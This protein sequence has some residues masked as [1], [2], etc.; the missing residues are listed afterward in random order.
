[1]SMNEIAVC[2][3]VYNDWEAVD[4]LLARFENHPQRSQYNLTYYLVD[5]ASTTKLSPWREFTGEAEVIRL[6]CNAGHQRALAVGLAHLYNETKCD[7]V[8]VMDAD[9]EDTVDGAFQLLN[10]CREHGR[11]VFAAR[12]LRHESL[13]FRLGYR[14][15]KMLYRLLTGRSISFGNFSVIPRRSLEQFVAAPELWNHYAASVI[16]SRVPYD[17]LR[18]ERGTRISGRSRM[19]LP[20]LVMHGLRSISVFSELVGIRLMAMSLIGLVCAVALTAVVVYVRVATTLAIPGWATFTCGILALLMMQLITNCL[21]FM[22]INLTA[23]SA[24]KVI[25]LREY[26]YQILSVE[27]IRV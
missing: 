24:A 3:P 16:K 14:S 4:I 10:F 23:R 19:N 2:M 5:D 1:M 9:G 20:E 13:W 6:R 8:L 26:T 27:K 15:Y 21:I 22:F 7:A 11:L 17:T 18:L 25:P 12:G